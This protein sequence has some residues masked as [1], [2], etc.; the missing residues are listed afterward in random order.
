VT[1]VAESEALQLSLQDLIVAQPDLTSRS[2]DDARRL[3]EDAIASHRQRVDAAYSQQRAAMSEDAKRRATLPVAPS[4][5]TPATASTSPQPVTVPPRERRQIRG[6]RCALLELIGVAVVVGL[7]AGG[8]L[9]GRPLAWASI[10]LAVFLGISIDYTSNL[11]R[12]WWEPV[13][14]LLVAVALA[15]LGGYL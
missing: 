11:D 12:R 7:A 3:A 10:G 15:F 8:T 6:L 14:G 2:S 5:L 1:D 4:V 13:G 9:N